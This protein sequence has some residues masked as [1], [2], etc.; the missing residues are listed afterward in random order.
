MKSFKDFIKEKPKQMPFL[1]T[2]FGKHSQEKKEPV[3][4]TTFGKHSQE[5]LKEET[6]SRQIADH[7]KSAEDKIHDFNSI[8]TSNAVRKYA[9]SSAGINGALHTLHGNTDK[10][11]HGNII[12]NAKSHVKALD[13]VLSNT[14][15]HSDTHVFTGLPHSPAQ[16][17]ETMKAK[18]GE[19]ITLHHPAFMSTS[20]SYEVAKDFARQDHPID[21]KKHKPTE[22]S[23]GIPG[24]KVRHVLKLHLP[25]GTRAGSVR[26]QASFRNENEVLLHRGHNIEIHPHPT[27]DTDGTHVWHAKVV[28]HT[29]KHI[30]D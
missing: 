6:A 1:E 13:D 8:E 16:H 9:M 5:K 12:N 25:Q 11:V 23:E 7:S 30:E 21:G 27:I 29:P 26:N 10:P 2:V 28:S 18:K 3:L 15:I 4:Q 17:F 22:G 19:S 24:G 20:T 14:K